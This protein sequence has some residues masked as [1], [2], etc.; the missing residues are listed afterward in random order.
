MKK[1]EVTVVIPTYNRSHILDKVVESYLQPDVKEII[2]VNDASTDN[3]QDVLES[4]ANKYS[5]VRYHTNPANVKQAES[6]NIGMRLAKTKYIYF[7]D[8][9]SYLDSDCIS[10]LKE[11]LISSDDIGLV[12]A[13]AIYLDDNYTPILRVQPEIVSFPRM[14]VNYTQKLPVPVDSIFCPSCFIIKKELALDTLFDSHSYLGN[15]YREETDFVIKVR[16]KGYKTLLHGK[17]SQINLPRSISSGGAHS[18]S[19]LKYVYFCIKNTIIFLNKH[20][21]YLKT[22]QDHSYVSLLFY[23]SLNHIRNYLSKKKLLHK[24]YRIVKGSN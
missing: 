22:Q 2:F 10:S 1:S 13:N 24:I 8:D 5:Q 9:D 4:L 18:G 3:T 7:G 23:S 21:S 20:Y 11:T 12:A 15:G 14:T 6:K 17:V 16:K 19:A